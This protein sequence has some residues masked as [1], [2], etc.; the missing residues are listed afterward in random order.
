MIE[1]I[2]LM[3]ALMAL[4]AGLTIALLIGFIYWLEIQND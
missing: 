2:L 3:T 4:G 1:N